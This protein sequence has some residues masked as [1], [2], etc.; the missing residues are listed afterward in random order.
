M[1][2]RAKQSFTAKVEDR[3]RRISRGEV[4]GS[5]DPVLRGRESL[6]DEIVETTRRGPGEKRATKK[7]STAKKST[8]EKAT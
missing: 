2:H 5:N 4:V 8:G 7:T 3:R 6:F 1:A